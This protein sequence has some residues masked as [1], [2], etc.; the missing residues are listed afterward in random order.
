[1]EDKPR[2]A[3][4]ELVEVLEPSPERVVPRCQH[5][6]TCGG[7][8]YQH[9]SYPAQLRV[10][11]AILKEQ[12]ERLGGLRDIPAVEIKAAQ[13]VW[14][15]RNH[16]QFHLTR[17]GKLGFQKVHSN[18]AFTIR[19][20]HLPEE[21]INWLWPQVE[22][23]PTAH[24]ERVSLRLGADEDMMLILESDNPQPLDF[25]IEEVPISVVQ[26][27]P[28]GN[29]VLAGSDHI[30]MDVSGKRFKVSAGSF[31]QVNTLQ[32]ESMVRHL[33]ESLPDRENMTVLDVYSGVGLFSAF[34][35]SKASRLV[36]IEISPA[37]CEDFTVN[38]DEYDH[39]ELYEASVEDVLTGVSFSPDLIVVDPP[40]AGLGMKTVAGLL[41]QGAEHLV[42]ISCDPATLARDGKQLAAGGYLLT[43]VTL[44]DMFPQTYHIESMSFWEK[45]D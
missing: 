25:S 20:C 15:Y 42:Y 33:I 35:A 32:A 38:L 44:F 26:V 3:R 34:L 8:H 45:R 13:D 6:G 37:A 17:E 14:N 5:F 27:G 10:K 28:S 41:T 24:L 39:V 7:C 23:E 21:G 18:Q 16:I 4:A 19:E 12:L 11:A 36:G 9:L 22:I 40:R 43:G 1:V 30:F 2:L 31:F 29:I